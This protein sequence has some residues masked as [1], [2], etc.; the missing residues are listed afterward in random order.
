MLIGGIS[1]W[2]GGLVSCLVRMADSGIPKSM[3]SL[4]MI[5][6]CVTG[7]APVVSVVLHDVMTPSWVREKKFGKA[8][9]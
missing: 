9:K 3:P 6:S 7:E 2:R 4:H 8:L 1:V 5:I